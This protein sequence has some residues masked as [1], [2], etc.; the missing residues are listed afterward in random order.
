M[1]SAASRRNRFQ[2]RTSF[3][4]VPPKNGAIS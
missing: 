3:L 1:R 4:A 2:A